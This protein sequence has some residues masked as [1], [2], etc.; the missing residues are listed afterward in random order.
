[1]ES[2]EGKEH[3]PEW[4]MRST[5]AEMVARHRAQRDREM[6]E[7]FHNDINK[8]AKDPDQKL[9]AWK[10]RSIGAAGEDFLNSRYTWSRWASSTRPSD[11]GRRRARRIASG[12]SR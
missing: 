1:M 11:G 5:K 7:D 4:N 3:I 8:I 9:Y 12:T 10:G 2:D 6:Y